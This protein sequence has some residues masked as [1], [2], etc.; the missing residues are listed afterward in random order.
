MSN[1]AEV[2][3]PIVLDV[4]ASVGQIAGAQ[5]LA[6]QDWQEAIRF[7]CSLRLMRDFQARL[8][9]LLPPAY[10]TVFLGSGDFHHL[11]WPLIA[12]L[13]RRQAIQVV[14]LDNHPDNM[15]YLFGVHC[16]SW[17]RRVAAL[18]F[19][20]QVHVV[21]ITS[22]DIGL[23]RSWENYWLPL[24]RGKLTYWSMGVDVSWARR[25]G[26]GR[27]FRSFAHVDELIAA[28]AAFQKTRDAPVY[29][30]IDKDVFAP[31]VARTNWDQGRFSLQNA[32]DIMAALKGP[33]A[34]SD[35][36]GEISQYA[37]RSR[38]KRWLSQ[39]D[40]QPPVEPPRLAS[41]Q[42]RQHDLNGHLLAALNQFERA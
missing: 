20:Q 25:A 12:R 19:V 30:S 15:R 37:Y 39:M 5:V 14:V 40:G 1:R 27:A 31:Q 6:L 38:L 8:E 9:R 16:G 29:L 2:L 11:S 33:L 35:I 13:Q 21:G 4:D 36:T 24:M 26:L 7:G 17:V 42:A 41:W 3:P 22:S 23:G 10:G 34:G 18:D 28:F 32:L